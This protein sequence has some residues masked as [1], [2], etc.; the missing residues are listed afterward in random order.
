M[1]PNK[2]DP[3]GGDIDPGTYEVNPEAMMWNLFTFNGKQ[4]P[5]TDPLTVK[6]GDKVLIR[7]GNLS[8]QSHP[9]H[10]HGQNFT[11]I[12]KDGVPIKYGATR[13]QD[14][15]LEFLRCE[16]MHKNLFYCPEGA[17]C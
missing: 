17:S 4:F 8:M 16:I 11:V 14:S 10:L 7:L 2:N 1:M 15:F 12:A 5:S 6:K 9:I 13:C 3:K